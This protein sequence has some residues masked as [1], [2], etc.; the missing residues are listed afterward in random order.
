M[1]TP[2]AKT[3]MEPPNKREN[4]QERKNNREQTS[5][6]E[7]QKTPW[8][9]HSVKYDYETTTHSDEEVKALKKYGV[10]RQQ[11]PL[12][13]LP[14]GTQHYLRK[15]LRATCSNAE[16]AVTYNANWFIRNYLRWGATWLGAS[17]GSMGDIWVTGSYSPLS[18]LEHVP[19]IHSTLR[20]ERSCLLENRITNKTSV[21][22]VKTKTSKCVLC[23][24]VLQWRLEER[25]YIEL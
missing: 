12:E 2:W 14:V 20:N 21:A 19:G 3:H 9:T 18:L 10:G 11:S 22:W 23:K 25:C 6:A 4:G 15:R 17:S 1:Q 8:W 24:D 5:W 16:E 13:K 7:E